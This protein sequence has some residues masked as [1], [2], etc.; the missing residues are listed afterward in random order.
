MVIVGSHLSVLRVHTLCISLWTSGVI[1]ITFEVSSVLCSATDG[2]IFSI[3]LT[4]FAPSRSVPIMSCLASSRGI[5]GS[6][7]KLRFVNL[8]VGE[9]KRKIMR[10]TQI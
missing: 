9:E 6:D 10:I 7:A 1:P 3:D 2:E 5:F 4:F 8:M